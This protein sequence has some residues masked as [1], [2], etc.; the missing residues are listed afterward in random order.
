MFAETLAT[1]LIMQAQAV[2]DS[3]P[4][5]DEDFVDGVEDIYTPP[6]GDIECTPEEARIYADWLAKA[7]V[8]AKAKAKAKP[9]G[10]TL[11]E[12]KAKAKAK[13]V[14]FYTDEAIA[15]ELSPFDD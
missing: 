8:K 13:V 14:A 6:E 5:T 9:S 1:K 2:Y 10:P 7:I 15:N 4:L 11:E 3:T 12:L